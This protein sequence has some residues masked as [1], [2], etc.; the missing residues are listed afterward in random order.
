M[1][2]ICQS[3][4]GERVFRVLR[5]AL[6]LALMLNGIVAQANAFDAQDG[7]ALQSTRVIYPSDAKKGIT[8]TVTNHTSNVYLLQSR[9]VAWPNTREETQLVEQ[10][11]K[12]KLETLQG[13]AETPATLSPFIVLPPLVRIEPQAQMTLRIQLTDNRL[14]T[15]RESIFMLAL[16]TIPSQSSAKDNADSASTAIILAL[17][18]NLKL[19]YRP[20]SL[21]KMEADARAKQLQFS[22]QAKVI[23]IKNPTPY[24]ITLSDVNIDQQPVSLAKGNMLAPFS[25][26]N[27]AFTTSIGKMVTWRIINDKGLKTQEYKQSLSFIPE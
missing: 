25:T 18:N 13:I 7:I 4:S 24:Y 16:K 15:D 20:E 12:Y 14:A 10:D 5:C 21:P 8:F 11:T 17:Q 23:S 26:R 22:Q 3:I 6:L 9:V 19:F 2:T 1:D 27:Y